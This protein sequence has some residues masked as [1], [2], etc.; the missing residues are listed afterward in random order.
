V[1]FLSRPEADAIAQALR[2][3]QLRFE[4]EPLGAFVLR[5]GERSGG[6]LLEGALG[7][8]QQTFAG[9]SLYPTV[10]DKA[11]ALFRSVA[12][13]HPYIDGNKRMGLAC[14]EIFLDLNGYALT[15]SQDEKVAVTFDVASAVEVNW[16]DL[17]RWLRRNSRKR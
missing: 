2:R 3:E 7:E 11:A 1:R 6:A 17:A 4:P 15:A 14:A 8:P 9:R 16:R 13:D 10:F 5:G 12:R